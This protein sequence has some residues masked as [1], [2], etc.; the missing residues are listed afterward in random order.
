MPVNPTAKSIL[1]ELGIDFEGDIAAQ[2]GET[3]IS[4]EETPPAPLGELPLTP[5]G[6]PMGIEKNADIL[7]AMAIKGLEEALIIYG[8]TS[9][10]GRAVLDAIK[11]LSNIVDESVLKEVEMAIAGFLG[12][13]P[14]SPTGMP[15]EIPIAPPAAAPGMAPGTSPEIAGLPPIGGTEKPT[16]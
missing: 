1:K 15:P 16:P 6:I 9:E 5:T 8:A 10:K 12:L 4:P 13:G 14:M 2:T 11:K 3:T 7:V